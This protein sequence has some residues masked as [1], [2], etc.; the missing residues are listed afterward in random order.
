[1][2]EIYAFTASKEEEVE[3]EESKKRKNK[4][5][6]K[7]ENV[8]VT[9]TVNEA[10]PHRVILWE[11]TRRQIEEADMEYS[12][13]MSRCIKKGILTKAMLAKKYSDTGGLLSE[14]DAT[15]LTRL[16]AKLADIQNRW[17][18]LDIKKKKSSLE[19]KKSVELNEEMVE[20]RKS[21]VELESTYQALFNHT[22]DVKAQNRS[23]LW[24]LV[25]LTYAKREEEE[26]SELASVFEGENYEEK[27][28][29][30]YALEDGNDEF[31]NSIKGKLLSFISLWYFSSGAV[32]SD[33]E[34]LNQDIEEGNL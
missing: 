32:T 29:A 16:Y 33:F 15:G 20:T 19:E 12:I 14:E 23:I 25:N 28:E 31:Y 17:M 34:Q 22:A 9:T 2:K 30:Y 6:G 1:M 5:S 4:D 21:I 3:K 26:D 13:E 18:K 11:P 8:T 10:V 24:Y 27:E 7:M